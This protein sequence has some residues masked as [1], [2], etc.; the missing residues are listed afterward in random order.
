MPKRSENWRIALQ[1]RWAEAQLQTIL[2]HSADDVRPRTSAAAIVASMMALIILLTPFAVAGLSALLIWWS[3]ATI[4]GV[5]FGALILLIAYFLL[6][7]VGRTDGGTYTREELPALF[8]LVDKIADRM[9]APRIDF[10][11]IDANYNA[12]VAR[13]GHRRRRLMGIGLALWQVLEN[14]ERVALIGH[15][16]AHEVNG[17]PARSLLIGAAEETLARWHDILMPDEYEAHRYPDDSFGASLALILM[18]I[19]AFVV[20]QIQYSLFLLHM[21]DSQRAEYYADLLAARTA[22][23]S[24][25]SGLLRHLVCAPEVQRAIGFAA[26]LRKLTGSELMH[27]LKP[28]LENLPSERLDKLLADM[29]AERSTID[30]SHPPTAFRL[31]FIAA[32][33]Q[34]APEFDAATA[35]WQAINAEL[36]GFLE[37]AG[38]VLMDEASEY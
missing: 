3:G 2:Q 24:A 25:M 18:R 4:V 12:Y 27:S 8:E 5:I 6:P 20:R 15:E 23:S 34:L 22:G 16:L 36:E 13:L 26:A 17:D 35:D 31:R 32:H 38:R 11:N 10:I 7:N 21:R 33:E 29:E 30:A 19:A 1:Q 37:P 9:T 14:D 28:Q